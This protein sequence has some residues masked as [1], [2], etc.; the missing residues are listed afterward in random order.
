LERL[1][2]T[3]LYKLTE[4]L[5]I[6]DTSI[7]QE[8]PVITGKL[9]GSIEKSMDVSGN[10]PKGIVVAKTFYAWWVEMGTVKMA[11][12]AFMRRGLAASISSIQ[13][14]FKSK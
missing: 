2:Q 13:G 9:K 3:L 5:D 6:L 7:K 11:P 4:S 14:I 8:C 12:R 10:K 1:N